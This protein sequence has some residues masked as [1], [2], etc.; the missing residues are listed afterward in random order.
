M[1]CVTEYAGHARKL[2]KELVL[3]K[4]YGIVV[5]SG[6]GLVHE[7]CLCVVCCLSTQYLL[8]MDRFIAMVKVSPS[9]RL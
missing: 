7:V 4:W 3:D 8:T 2:V 9:V 1:L 6:D 5:V